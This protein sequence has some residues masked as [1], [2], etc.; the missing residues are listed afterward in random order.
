MRFIPKKF[1]KLVSKAKIE[2]N[3][4]IPGSTISRFSL[5]SIWNRNTAPVEKSPSP[6]SESMIFNKIKSTYSRIL[7]V[8]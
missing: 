2:S 7:K 5:S 4:K 8:K 6:A 3:P 1:S